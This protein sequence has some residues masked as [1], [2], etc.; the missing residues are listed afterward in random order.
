MILAQLKIRRGVTEDAPALAKF[1]ARTF[2]EAFGS[3]NRPEDMQAHLAASFGIPQQTKELTN[4][5]VTTLLALNADTLVAYAQVQCQAPPPC[6]IDTRAVKLHRFYADQS[7][8]GLG[9]AQR[10]MAAVYQAASELGGQHLWLSVWERNP[11]G[12]A[13]Y[14]KVGF[15]D[16]GKADFFVGTDRQRD[17]VLVAKVAKHT[18]RI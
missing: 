9:V 2:T 3:D 7:A 1:A 11:R 6:V 15:V 16:V 5:R 18:P 4:P 10:L 13:F 8:H 14:M 12:I 17:R